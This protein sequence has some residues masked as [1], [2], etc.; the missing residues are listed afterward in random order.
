[1]RAG[2]L[3]GTYPYPGGDLDKHEKKARGKKG[4]RKTRRENVKRKNTQTKQP[5]EFLFKRIPFSLHNL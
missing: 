1:M 3:S 5:W 2:L 4:T